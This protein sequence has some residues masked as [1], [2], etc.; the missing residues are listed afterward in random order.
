[1]SDGGDR[2]LGFIFAAIGAALFLLAGVLGLISGAVFLALGHGAHG[3]DAWSHAVV[4]L[5]LGLIV[6]V[7]AMIGRGRGRDQ[8]LMAGVVL[9]VLALVGWLALGLGFGLL[10]ILGEVCVVV[11]ALVFLL[12]NR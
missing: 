9:L 11:G 5:V 10:S 8:A 3:L 2:R 6:G 12:S 7:F 1:M 4:L